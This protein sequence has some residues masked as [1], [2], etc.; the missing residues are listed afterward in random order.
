MY[1]VYMSFPQMRQRMYV[2]MYLCMIELV[3]ILRA[4][5][6]TKLGLAPGDAE[7]VLVDI[8]GSGQDVHSGLQ[9]HHHIAKCVAICIYE[10]M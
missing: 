9:L 1:N 10:C 8:V 6:L 7:V 3:R 4:T 2:C 5:Y